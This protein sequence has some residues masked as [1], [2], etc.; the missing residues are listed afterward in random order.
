[1]EEIFY[2]EAGVSYGRS[3]IVVNSTS[4]SMYDKH[5]NVKITKVD[6]LYCVTAERP[7]YECFLDDQFDSEIVNQ[8]IDSHVETT[9]GFLGFGGG[10]RYVHG[11]C[12]LKHRNRL[13]ISSNNITI[14]TK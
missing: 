9:S 8:V 5:Y 7:D 2:P 1:M 14:V 6:E 3:S 12:E 4:I 10:R 11:W 13:N